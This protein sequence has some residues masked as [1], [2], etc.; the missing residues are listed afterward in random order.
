MVQF[1]SSFKIWVVFLRDWRKGKLQET[2]R[3]EI[4]KPTNLAMFSFASSFCSRTP[5]SVSVLTGKI[6]N[7]E[8]VGWT[9]TQ[10][11][12]G[13]IF[14]NCT[15]E[16][17]LSFTQFGENVQN[18]LRAVLDSNWKLC[19]MV[20]N[21]GSSYHWAIITLQCNVGATKISDPSQRNSFFF[22]NITN[23][24]WMSLQCNWSVPQSISSTPHQQTPLFSTMDL[25][26]DYY[27]SRCKGVVCWCAVE[28]LL[29]NT[30]S[31]SRLEWGIMKCKHPRA[32]GGVRWFTTS[33]F[34]PQLLC[35]GNA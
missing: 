23:L 11:I 13:C 34:M 6:R 18:F 25:D 16:P 26:S 28:M 32:S 9:H 7:T 31:R 4:H 15:L 21:W 5:N 20:P 2:P 12:K 33:I 35:K 29:H 14:M 17:T 3:R 10:L 30:I 1:L 24:G 8:G 19:F 27:S 22:H